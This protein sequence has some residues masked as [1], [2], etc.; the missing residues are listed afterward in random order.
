MVMDPTGKVYVGI[1][2]VI[3]GA[4]VAAMTFVISLRMKH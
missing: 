1:V 3:I 2:M 4:V